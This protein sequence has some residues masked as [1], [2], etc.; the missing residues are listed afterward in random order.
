[1]KHFLPKGRVFLIR[2]KF[3]NLGISEEKQTYLH[4]LKASQFTMPKYH[5]K[6]FYLLLRQ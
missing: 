3:G 4:W 2:P 1:M 5:S 6:L